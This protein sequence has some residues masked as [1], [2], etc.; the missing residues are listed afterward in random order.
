MLRAIEARQ[1]LRAAQVGGLPD[2]RLELN[3]YELLLRRGGDVGAWI[4]EAID[5]EPLHEPPEATSLEALEARP[6]RRA[7]R[8]VDEPSGFL[9]IRAAEF[10]ELDAEGRCVARQVRELVLPAMH[11]LNTVAVA[12]LCRR[13]DE[14]LIGLADD[15]LPASQCFDGHSELLVAPAW[16]LPENV[17]GLRTSRAFVT[18]RLA[19]E[20]GLTVERLAELGGRYH[21]SAGVTPEVVYPMAAQVAA[22]EDSPSPLLWLP[23]RDLIHRRGLLLDGHLRVVALRAAHALG[24][25]HI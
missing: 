19:A 4:G 11:S 16:R 21:P 13:D 2:A 14:V 10:E 8:R 23:L 7:F 25:L 24:L 3:V 17:V 12:A 9:S 5:L 6:R 20:H 1:L 22:V 15:D 18:E